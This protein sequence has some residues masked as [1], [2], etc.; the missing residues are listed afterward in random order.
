MSRPR[1]ALLAGIFGG[2]LI[3]IT[4]TAVGALP[5]AASPAGPAAFTASQISIHARS[6][7]YPTARHGLVDGRA[8][9]VFRSGTRSQ[10]RATISGSVSTSAPSDT[11]TL[12]ARPAG[13]SSYSATGTPVPLTPSGGSAPYSFTVSPT[14]A[15]HYEV[16]VTS[17]SSTITS[18][19][20]AVYVTLGGRD[21]AH[22]SC[23]KR[24]CTYRMRVYTYVPASAYRAESRKHVYLYLAVGYPSLPKDYTLTR[25]A[26]ETAPR[27]IGASE[28]ER[29]LTWHIRLRNGGGTWRTVG[30]TKDTETQDGL[31]LPGRHGCGDKHV[32]RRAEYLG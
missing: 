2:V 29:T 24:T 3:A 4:L 9:V 15:T 7:H 12:L 31:G 20:V 19:P 8:L 30:C 18:R 5:A 22:T 14:V 13:S 23:G 17:S 6:P 10:R 32:S 25:S 27:K 21:T 28:Y 11:V 1:S 26:T 16:S